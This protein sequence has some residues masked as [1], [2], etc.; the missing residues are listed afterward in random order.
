[1]MRFLKNLVLLLLGINDGVFEEEWGKK[2]HGGIS[3][4]DSP[5]IVIHIMPMEHP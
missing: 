4:H 5:V 1:M 2:Y 3:V